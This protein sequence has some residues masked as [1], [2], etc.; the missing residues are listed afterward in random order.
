MMFIIQVGWIWFSLSTGEAPLKFCL[1]CTPSAPGSAWLEICTQVKS[2]W[3]QGFSQWIQ[4]G[5]FFILTDLIHLKVINSVFH[6]TL[7]GD[8]KAP[9]ENNS[10]CHKPSAW[11]K[12][13]ASHWLYLSTFTCSEG[14]PE[15]WLC[16]ST[17]KWLKLSQK[18]VW[19][20][21]D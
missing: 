9:L 3:Y 15:G 21:K 14:H 6:A 17:F 5:V 16:T 2:C 18:E 4:L 20:S 10:S 19:G 1:Y 11:N 8:C 13:D 7:S 12:L